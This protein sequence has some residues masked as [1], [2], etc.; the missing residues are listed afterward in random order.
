MKEWTPYLGTQYAWIHADKLTEEAA[1]HGVDY[2][3]IGMAH[4]GRLSALANVLDKPL[5]KIFA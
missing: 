5:E 3:G 1:R 4:R 2:I